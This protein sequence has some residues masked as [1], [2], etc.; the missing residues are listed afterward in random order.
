MQSWVEQNYRTEFE[1]E[2]SIM[3]SKFI[4]FKSKEI[5]CNMKEEL[6]QIEDTN[7]N[8]CNEIKELRKKVQMSQISQ[9]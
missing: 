8:L 7:N 1:S 9:E 4:N 6:R 3:K 2:I 5:L